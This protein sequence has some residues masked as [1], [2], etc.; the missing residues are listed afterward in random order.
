VAKDSVLRR[1]ES[2]RALPRVHATSLIV[3]V[4]GDVVQPR[5]GR[6]WLGS[7]IRL[8]Q[9]LALNER[10][11]RTAVFRLVQQQWL[12][13]ESLGR[14]A[15]YLLTDIGRR[16]FDDAASRIYASH[17][18]A[19]DRRWRLLLVVGEEE[20]KLRE[21]IHRSLSWQGFGSLGSACH[22]HPTAD[23][24]GALDA[25]VA[26]GLGDHL[27]HL[28]PLLAASASAGQCADDADLVAQA[29]D[30]PSIASSYQG[31][32]DTY[33][34]ILRQLRAA[35]RNGL[36]P[37]D[38]FLLRVLLVHDYRRLLLR[39]PGLPEALLPRHW[40]G[41]EVRRLCGDLYRRILPP[42]EQHL[43]ATFRLADGTSPRAE[44]SLAE[45]FPDVD[46]LAEAVAA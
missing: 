23:L 28:V 41:R 32:V 22:V 7:L 21:R 25:L 44:D 38:A 16:R 30:L 37:Q 45:R 43:D 36:A 4:L 6:I 12:R 31:F 42:A 13:S 2:H 8:L 10:L 14:R 40:P 33:Q 15:D 9:P 27:G 1:I 46:P 3:T 20:P 18:P 24:H 5:G 39:D 26:D 19:W 29:W 35:G 11:V 17:P 34:P